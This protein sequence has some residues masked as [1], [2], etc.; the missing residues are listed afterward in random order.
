MYLLRHNVTSY[1]IIDLTL[2]DTLIKTDFELNKTSI[3]WTPVAK[4]IVA[5]RK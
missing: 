4:L 5:I 1:R 2:K 3:Q